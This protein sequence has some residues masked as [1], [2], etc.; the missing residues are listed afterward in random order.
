ML[1][2]KHAKGKIH[3]KLVRTTFKTSRVMDFFTEK[4]L[5][6]QTGHEVRDW[7]LVIVKE[8]VDNALDA[9][10]DADIAPIVLVTADAAGITVT[11]NGPGLPETTLEGAM[12]FT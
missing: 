7:P 4:E 5:V 11:D 10:E 8:L 3:G 9:C 12:D 2:Q 1:T 6:T